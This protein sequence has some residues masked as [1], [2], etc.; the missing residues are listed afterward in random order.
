MTETK[1]VTHAYNG[2]ITW[3]HPLRCKEPYVLAVPS[4]VLFDWFLQKR[5]FKLSLDEVVWFLNRRYLLEV[6]QNG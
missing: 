3:L 4:L 1:R 5:R 2:F 6:F